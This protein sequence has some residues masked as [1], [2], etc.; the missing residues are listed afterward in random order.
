MEE[1]LEIEA[2]KVMD[3]LGEKNRSFKGISTYENGIFD[4]LVWL[5]GGCLKPDIEDKEE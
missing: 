1:K 2:I 4:T 3:S 5:F